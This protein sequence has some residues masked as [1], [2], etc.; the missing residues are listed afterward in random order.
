MHSG[1][2]EEGAATQHSMP[3][4][5]ATQPHASTHHTGFHAVRPTSS[6]C[7]SGVDD[8]GQCDDVEFKP[9]AIAVVAGSS[10]EVQ[11]DTT[12]EAGCWVSFRCRSGRWQE[13]LAVDRQ[14]G[15]SC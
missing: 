11:G 1:A 12:D 13:Q 3:F 4:C 6:S 15:E 9:G 7:G 8:G 14:S 10:S 2:V 5:T